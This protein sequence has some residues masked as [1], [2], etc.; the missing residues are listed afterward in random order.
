MKLNYDKVIAGQDYECEITKR[1]I[2]ENTRFKVVWYEY[3]SYMFHK[4]VSNRR[5]KRW[6]KYNTKE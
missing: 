1:K 3:K 2:K 6:L 4:R 5:I